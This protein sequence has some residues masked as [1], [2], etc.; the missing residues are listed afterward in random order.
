MTS[1]MREPF[2][3]EWMTT[4]PERI[5]FQHSEPQFIWEA[6]PGITWSAENINDDD[7]EYVRA[8][9]HAAAQETQR[10]CIAVGLMAP[11]EFENA[12]AAARR[13]A[14]EEAAQVCEAL[15]NAARGGLHGSY[16]QT[17]TCGIA[18]RRIRSRKENITN[19]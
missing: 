10:R 12:I 17:M 7:V 16:S 5:Y 4:W 14:L 18:A 11:E 13:A 2:G 6:D 1:K 15:G 8:D 3:Q 19:E 9:L